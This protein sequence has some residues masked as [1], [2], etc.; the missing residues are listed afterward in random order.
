MKPF[1]GAA[2]CRYNENIFLK[3]AKFL[4]PYPADIGD[5][6]DE[7]IRDLFWD[8]GLMMIR[9][10]DYVKIAAARCLSFKGIKAMQGT[11]L[12]QGHQTS[13]WDNDLDWVHDHDLRGRR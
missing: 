2:T 6:S 4:F 12:A 13:C 10:K 11:K 1:V 7:A 8:E 3:M 5:V 9:V